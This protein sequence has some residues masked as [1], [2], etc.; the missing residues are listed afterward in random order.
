MKLIQGTKD[1]FSGLKKITGK[2]WIIFGLATFFLLFGVDHLA[3]ATDELQGT[4]TNA[5]DTIE[6]TGMTYIYIAE[7]VVA[8][9]TYIKTRSMWVWVGIIVIM[10]AT[11]VFEHIITQSVS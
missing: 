11:G 2:Q 1:F 9:F 5:T 8:L 4:T 10:I 6:G 3:M 7:F